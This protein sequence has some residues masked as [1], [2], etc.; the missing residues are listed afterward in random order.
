MQFIF[1]K[2]EKYKKK[3]IGLL[4]F[5]VIGT[6]TDLAI[7][8]L[9]AYMIDQ[10]IPTSSKD[11]IT[12][13]ILL[14]ILM[15]LVVLF[16]W[17]FNMKANRMA[18]YVAAYTVRDIRY[19]LFSKIETL[20]A[21]QVDELTQT[22]LISRMTTDTYNIYSAVGS[23]QRLGVRAP[24]LFIGGIVVS[25]FLDWVLALIMV[26][27]IPF[28]MYFSLRTSKMGRPLYTDIQVKVDK[29]IRT[30]R[31]NITGARVVKALSMVEHENYKF[32]LNNKEV[33]ESELKATKSMSKIRPLVDVIMNLGLV[34]VLIIGAY[35]V[36]N[37][38]TKVG[39][40]LAFV[41]YFT[42]I[43]NA[44]MSLTRVFIQMSK[45]T[46][47]S[48]R[49]IEVL[50]FKTDMKNGNMEV[51]EVNETPHIE[52][53]HVYFSYNQKGDHLEDINFKLYK[54]QTL[55][56]LGATGS[57]KTTII[58]LIMRF[59]DPYQGEIKMFGKNLKDL[60]LSALRKS[61]GLVL[62]TDLILSDTI[63]ENIQFSRKDILP[64]DIELAKTIAQANFIDEMPEKN[65]E[66]MT[67]RGTNISGGQKQRLLIARAVAGKPK[68]L[69][70][71][72][73]SSALDYQTDMNMRLSLK[74]H[75]SETTKIIVAQRISSIKEADLI[76]VI[77][78]GKIIAS[79]THETLE[80][81]SEQYQNIIKHQLGGELNESTNH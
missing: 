55:G 57:G 56:I 37:S 49:I 45:A 43:L 80:Q 21:K 38:Q 1:N 76:L 61:I 5:K 54:G 14:G 68:L 10:L 72:D 8:Y 25:F 36:F 47:S 28:I 75:L 20:S 4:I 59:Y 13:I 44:T 17:F 71:D 23:I 31:E 73:A 24:I 42:I 66:K 69:I 35:R 70:L 40:I 19:E 46:A 16:G 62:Q 64:E 78:D 6:L 29:L 34:V 39:E 11:D 74:E 30:L 48:L 51:F 77:E 18:E 9:T 63:Y 60:D 81:T 52:F 33:V 3:V 15:L 67:Q 65:Y 50:D 26:A 32:D 27:M 79:G 2:M 58:N 53:S 22:S 12:K 41:T 7:P